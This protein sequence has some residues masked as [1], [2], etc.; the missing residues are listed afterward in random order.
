M[1]E[2]YYYIPSE[3]VENAVHCGLKLSKWFDREVPINGE[4]R[5]CLTALLNPR[6]DMEKYMSDSYVCV[7]LEVLPKYCFVADSYLYLMGL[8]DPVAME[9][10]QASIMPVEDYIFGS[11]RLPECLVTSTLIGE[12][13]SIFGKKLESPILF[14]NSEE[15][16]LNNIME[17]YQEGHTAF[18]DAILYCFY[19]KLSEMGKLEK[20]QDIKN[21]VAVF[22]DRGV[23][24]RY[25]LKIPN[26]D[27][28]FSTG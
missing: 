6:D 5:K 4:S 27:K 17:T 1:I 14:S 22:V 8:S 24:K 13:V 10:Y 3:D 7:K 16:Y 12:C 15:L 23:N 25:T 9:L 28:Y 2:V 20:Y 21:G 26:M 18:I 19:S 11:Y